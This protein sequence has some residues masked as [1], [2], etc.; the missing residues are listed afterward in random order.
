MLRFSYKFKS[1]LLQRL[2]QENAAAFPSSVAICPRAEGLAG[3]VGRDHLGLAERDKHP[4][5]DDAADSSTDGHVA[6]T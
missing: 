5:L 2:Q 6:V 4:G 1:D 3:P